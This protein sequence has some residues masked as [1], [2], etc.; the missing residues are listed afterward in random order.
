MTINGVL[1]ISPLIAT[2]RITGY[3][4]EA[5]GMMRNYMQLKLRGPPDSKRVPIVT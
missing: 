5:I 1:T 4:S 3:L 2:K